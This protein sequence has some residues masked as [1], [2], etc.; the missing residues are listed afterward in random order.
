MTNQPKLIK[1][2]Y[3]IHVPKMGATLE[4][5]EKKSYNEYLEEFTAKGWEIQT[6][7]IPA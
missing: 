3:R 1:L 4:F 6:S 7:I 2:V 5:A